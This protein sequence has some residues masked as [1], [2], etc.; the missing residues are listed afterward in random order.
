MTMLLLKNKPLVQNLKSH[1]IKI[2]ELI[3]E[4]KE[5]KLTGFIEVKLKNAKDV[6]LYNSGKVVKVLKI[7]SGV[8]V[9]DKDNVVFDLVRTGAMFSAYDMKEY[10]VTMIL[11]SIENEPLYENL[12]TEFIDVKKLLKKLQKDEFSGVV[13]I[14]WDK[15]CEGAI[16]TESGL[17]SASVYK[18][19]DVIEEGAEAL[20]NMVRRSEKRI[21]IV[22]VFTNEKRSE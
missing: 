8:S 1:Y 13:Q 5:K 19:G 14:Y 6:L 4:M 22:N 2:E 12:T 10:I 21:A 3:L 17:P 16:L 7:N 11:F 18:E 15:E 20:E 9:I